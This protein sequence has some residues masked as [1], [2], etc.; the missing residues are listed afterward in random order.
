[1]SKLNQA[2]PT[3][4]GL[5]L[6]ARYAFAPNY[7]KYC[8]PS[9]NREIGEALQNQ[10][11]ERELREILNHFEAAVPYLNLIAHSNHI[12]DLFDPRVVEAYWLGNKLLFNLPAQAVYEHLVSTVKPRAKTG[13]RKLETKIGFGIKPHHSFHVFDVYRTAGFTRD[14]SKKMAVIELINNCM[15]KWARIA[16]ITNKI[17]SS[18]YKWGEI[19]VESQKIDVKGNK[20]IF[21]PEEKTVQNIGLD[22]QEGDLVSLHW[23]F[24][25][26]KI[27]MRQLNNLK[28]WTKYH[29]EISNIFI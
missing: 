12:A 11:D 15:I 1:L 10:Y 20:F 13:W 17:Q 22:L 14:G 18:N 29:L 6:F 3:R 27:S 24:V 25:C 8:G 21:V 5:I 2:R 28:F 9:S 26:D 23:G 4:K 7:F 16:Q 19:R